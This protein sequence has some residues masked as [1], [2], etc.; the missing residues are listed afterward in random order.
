MKL[1]TDVTIGKR[2]AVGFGIALALMAINLVIGISL[3]GGINSSLDQIVTR[4]SVK[5]KYANDIRS[6]LADISAL[7][8]EIATA[9]K[10]QDRLDAQGKINELRPKYK[11]AMEE[12]ARLEDNPEGAK[13]INTLKEEV[14]KGKEANNQVIELGLKGETKEATA[15]YSEVKNT[16]KT[17]LDRADDVIR[18]NET[19]TGQAYER[20]KKASSTG[21]SAFIIL[22]IITVLAGAW[23]SRAITRSITIPIMRSANHIDLMA[24]GDFSIPVSEHALKRKDEMG[25]FAKSMHAMNTNIGKILSE[26]KASAASVASASTQLSA[27]AESL[28]NGAVSQVDMATQVATAST[29]MNQATEDIARNSNNIALSA[30]ET[31]N[32]A[33]GG[34]EIVQKAIQEVNLIAETVET[35]SGF[36]KELGQESGKIGDIVTTINE[37]AEQTNL[38]ALNAAIEAARAGEHGRGFAV[39]A[40]EV[41]KL[42]ERTTASTT[43]IGHMITTVKVGVEKTVQSMNQAKRNVQSG[44]QFSSQAQTALKDIITSIDSLYGGVQHAASSIEEMS[45]TTNQITRDINNISDVTRETLSSSEEMSQAAAGLSGLAE[46]LEKTVGMFKV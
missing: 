46:N 1:F 25:I 45:A 20:A 5:I 27:S 13:L 9:E 40:D 28:S 33:R 6:A 23:L 3:L 14:A 37:I 24:K 26:M 12:L 42:A 8:G 2:L 32:I 4:S 44:V 31:V 38:L 35:V 16:L 7:S 21:R 34:Q 30:G 10:P 43:E 17:Y 19:A 39:V 22:G 29:E 36:V 41:K 15:K 18:Y 11:K